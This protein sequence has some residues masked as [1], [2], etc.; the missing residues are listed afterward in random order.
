MLKE[1]QVSELLLECERLV[2]QPL[3]QIRGNLTK[4]E[5]R[6]AAIFELLAIQAFAAL[7]K[8]EYE[9]FPN[10]PDIRLTLPDGTQAWVEVAFLYDKYWKHER[11][12]RELT[13]A[14]RKHA[15]A[16][17]VAPEK[18][19]LRFS[20]V[21]TAAGYERR[22][23]EQHEVKKF[24]KGEYVKD[25]FKRIQHAPAEPF[26]VVKPR[27]QLSGLL[28]AFGYIWKRQRTGAGSAQRSKTASALQNHQTESQPAYRR[29]HAH[30]LCGH[31]YQQGPGPQLC[32]GSDHCRGS[33]P[34]SFLR[35]SLC[36]LCSNRGDQTRFSAVQPGAKARPHMDLP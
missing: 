31:G 15:E 27:L 7:G 16:Q 32:P 1:E 28:C 25:L 21:P 2:E 35:N 29:R 24:L 3:V 17:G 36:G 26:T 20:G 4:A 14:M 12:S 18:I 9:P 5:N 13:M 22:L 34:S 8:V 30:C 33:S 11:Q 19:S 6:S 23:P 10:S